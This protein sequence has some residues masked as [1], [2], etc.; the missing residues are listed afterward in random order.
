MFVVLALLG[1][2]IAACDPTLGSNPLLPAPNTC[3]TGS[4]PCCPT[5]ATGVTYYG[6]LQYGHDN[7]F[8]QDLFLD[9]YLP[10]GS[11]PFPAVVVVHGGG[12]IAGNKCGMQNQAVYLAQHGFAA[13]SIDYPLASST[14]HPWTEQPA[15]TRLAVRWVRTFASTLHVDSNKVALWGSSAGADLAL[16]AAYQAQRSDPGARVQAVVGWSGVYDF[17]TEAYRDPSN[18]GHHNDG[19]EYFGCADL[20]NTWC[21]AALQSAAPISYAAHDDPPTLVDVS[22]NTNTGCESVE[23]QNAVEMVE[24]LHAAA[25]LRSST[26]RVRARTRSATG[27]LRP[28]H[29]GAAR[30]W[31]TPSRSGAIS[32]TERRARGSRP[33]RCL[34]RSRARRS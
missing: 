32:S 31:T 34:R 4:A 15:D 23:P 14:R 9:A 13:F 24:A 20:T 7:D 11:G 21:F 1:V 27:R 18:T 25:H 6:N 30:W 5:S 17:V 10:A 29:P 8:G 28:I 3:A 26:R 33:R 16:V 2:L 22:T 12:H 19:L